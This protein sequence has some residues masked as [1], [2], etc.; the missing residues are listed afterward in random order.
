VE[1]LHLRGGGAPTR[2]RR[3]S[4][5]HAQGSRRGLRRPCSRAARGS[6]ALVA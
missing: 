3:V 2:R 4:C 6:G 1:A 5:A